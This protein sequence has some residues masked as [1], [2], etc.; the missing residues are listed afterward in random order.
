MPLHPDEQSP[1]SVEIVAGNVLGATVIFLLFQVFVMIVFLVFAFLL[2]ELGVCS[3]AVGERLAIVF[4]LLGEAIL[5]TYLVRMVRKG[6]SGVPVKPGAY[7]VDPA[8]AP[9]TFDRRVERMMLL[10]AVLAVAWSLLI[11]LG[12]SGARIA[13]MVIEGFTILF[14]LIVIATS[15]FVRRK[16]STAA[17]IAL[18]ATVL[19]LGLATGI[20][21]P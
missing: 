6:I 17:V 4:A 13:L 1:D 19:S 5:V 18:A 7:P 16:V 20:F 9:S 15:W 11:G 21:R 14:L 8:P 12:P 3:H 10:G 2:P